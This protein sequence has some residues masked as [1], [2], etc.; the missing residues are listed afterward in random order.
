MQ[1]DV[2][3]AS[4]GTGQVEPLLPLSPAD[5]GR[6]QLDTLGPGVSAGVPGGERTVHA[7]R[8]EVV[9]ATA[10]ACVVRRGEVGR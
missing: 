2:G 6:D 5:H 4:G 1:S 8:A 9:V 7:A 3:T 10:V